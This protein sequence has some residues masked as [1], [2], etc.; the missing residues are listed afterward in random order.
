[1]VKRLSVKISALRI[2]CVCAS[3]NN[4]RI[5]AEIVALKNLPT[6]YSRSLLK[7]HVQTD[8]LPHFTNLNFYAFRT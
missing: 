4:G 5:F 2:N 8:S 7:Q 1:M 3:I 6:S